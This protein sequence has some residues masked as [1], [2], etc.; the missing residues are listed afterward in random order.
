MN[1]WHTIRQTPR[2]EV[3]LTTAYCQFN[4]VNKN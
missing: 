2:L 4:I 1:M 3:A